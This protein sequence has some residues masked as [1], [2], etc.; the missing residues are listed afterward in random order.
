MRLG[1]LRQVHGRN[2]V[3]RRSLALK[4]WTQKRYDEKKWFCRNG[5]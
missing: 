1:L 5:R 3:V 2:Y 4:I